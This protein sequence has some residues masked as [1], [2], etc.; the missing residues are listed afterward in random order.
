[1]A[2][3]VKISL[4]HERALL[5]SALKDK[6][7][8]R[9]LL[10][11]LL[12]SDFTDPRHQKIFAAIREL[13]ERHLE[14]VP[15]TLVS[16]ADDIEI[17]DL[18]HLES[19]AVEPENIDFHLLR[20]RWD[21]ARSYIFREL[22][23]R[24]ELALRDPRAEILEVARL[25]GE[26]RTMVAQA[27]AEPPFI[28]GEGVAAEYLLKLEARRRTTVERSSGIPALDA[29]LTTPF[30]PGKLSI[31]TACPSIG[32]TTF[33][34]NLALHQS[35]EWNVGYIAWESGHTAATDIICA[36][37]LGIPLTTL[38]KRT[39]DLSDDDF[40]RIGE[41]LDSLYAGNH[42][43]SFLRRP[44]SSM[45]KSK[46]SWEINNQVIDWFEAQLDTWNRDIIYWDLFEKLLPDRQPQAISWAIDRIQT[47]AQEKQV[48]IVLLHQ[49]ALKTLEREADKRPSRSVL[50]GSAGY[51]EAPDLV[52]GLYRDAVYNPGLLD[53]EIEILILKQRDG[54]WPARIICDWHGPTC[55]VSGGRQENF[56]VEDDHGL[57]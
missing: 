43:L 52:L 38:V 33:A 46:Y 49:I 13:N 53:A 54:K 9:K 57:V 30:A 56:I 14:Y 17:E 5:G 29:L 16:L 37:S 25:A 47:I 44:P 39:R 1:M 21:H 41:L 26:I 22:M 19:F 23:G 45:M 40:D 35:R 36:R 12:P 42:R 3:A 51:I 31:I 27:D 8:R 10:Q 24:L 2:T 6:D 28:H 48:H 18:T 11:A 34:L 32:K 15:A 20:S 55:R 7:I 4:L 50:K